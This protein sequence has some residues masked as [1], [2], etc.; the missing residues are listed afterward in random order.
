[1]YIVLYSIHMCMAAISVSTAVFTCIIK[2]K[3]IFV[4]T[5]KYRLVIQYVYVHV[6]NNIK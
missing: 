3:G 5:G 4:V 2:A 1:M 6:H